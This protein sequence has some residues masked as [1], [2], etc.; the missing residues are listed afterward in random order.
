M[1]RANPGLLHDQSSVKVVCAGDAGSGKSEL[2]RI[3]GDFEIDAS[4][5][6]I[7]PEPQQPQRHVRRVPK[8]SLATTLLRG[9]RKFATFLAIAVAV[10]F[11]AAALLMRFVFE[12][13]FHK[14]PS[15]PLRPITRP[16]QKQQE[17]PF[18]VA[19]VGLQNPIAEFIKSTIGERIAPDLF[20]SQFTTRNVS[21][22]RLLDLMANMGHPNY[23]AT[24]LLYDVASRLSFDAAEDQL[25]RHGRNNPAWRII[26]VG[27]KPKDD[28]ERAV[29]FKVAQKAARDNSA[30]CALEICLTT[31]EGIPELWAAAL[32]GKL[33][34]AALVS[35]EDAAQF[36][37][38]S[39]IDMQQLMAVPHLGESVL[40]DAT[41]HEATPPLRLHA[42]F[43]SG[44]LAQEGCCPWRA[45][46]D[47]AAG[48]G[49]R[50]LYAAYLAA[51]NSNWPDFAVVAFDISRK[52]AAAPQ[53]GGQLAQRVLTSIAD[54]AQLGHHGSREKAML[55]RAVA[56]V[57]EERGWDRFAVAAHSRALALRPHEPQ[58]LHSLALALLRTGT[59]EATA[60]AA[61][62]L[63][64]IVDSEWERRFAQIE[65]VALTDRNNSVEHA[66]LGLQDDVLWRKLSLDLRVSLVWASDDVDVELRVREPAAGEEAFVFHNYTQQ[67]GLVT[68]D[69]PGGCGPVEY[70]LPRATAGTY[71]VLAR[72]FSQGCS[73]SATA[74]QCSPQM[75]R[76]AP[77]QRVF[78]LLRVWTYFGDPVLQRQW[79][80]AFWLDP[81]QRDPI[82]IAHVTF[83][84]TF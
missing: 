80:R 34:D 32:Q 7:V 1:F 33:P 4:S 12:A 13:I 48:S 73:C 49:A 27:V 10:P 36:S 64:K 55:L 71:T 47:T 58:G 24:L 6:G 29:P 38:S 79:A 18:F 68:Y 51:R 8:R 83:S 82:E 56:F 53:D 70:Q 46:V 23:D 61:A 81:D 62:L 14:Q 5:F 78:C 41:P 28:A 69:M 21:V 26:L 67:G 43:M 74:G 72:I 17:Q 25:E 57:A 54:Y 52:L 76:S 9:S 35:A 11:M 19:I 66:Q 63:D 40:A 39:R 2:M 20:R 15:L 22:S 37:E 75:Q 30:V 59:K 16:Q 45:A 42:H 65:L 77:G 44:T 31:L 84:D 3:L 50:A 60:E